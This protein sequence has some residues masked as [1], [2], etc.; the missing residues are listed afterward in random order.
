MSRIAVLT[1][2]AFLF[3]TP[4]WS[5]APVLPTAVLP[6]V[7]EKRV[8][9][10]A[11]IVARTLSHMGA[12][13]SGTL[14][15][16]SLRDGDR[17]KRGQV[18]ARFRCL[19][20]NAVLTRTRAEL[21]KRGRISA[22][23]GLARQ[24]GVN[25]V[26]DAQVAQAEVEV[27]K[28]EVAV[29]DAAVQDCTMLAPFDGRA[30]DVSVRNNQFV[31]AGAPLFDA[32]DDSVL[33]VEVVLPSSAVGWL[34]VGSIVAVEVG[35]TVTQHR[36]VLDRYAGRV[37]PVSQTIKAYARLEGDTSLLL[38]GMSGTAE[39]SAKAGK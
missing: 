16:F 20:E 10:P 39:F 36:A 15:E 27:A 22:T 25:T 2:S 19:K 32:L 29:A 11:Q 6:T 37:D 30:A 8:S 35:E 24:L 17:F 21:M 33:E 18:I 13:M 34:P 1:L 5:Q 4:A 28:G 14:V 38:P 9:V 12:G 23:Q 31:A 7:V 3:T 26:Q